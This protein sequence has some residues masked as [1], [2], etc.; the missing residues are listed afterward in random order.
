MRRAAIL[1]GLLVVVGLPFTRPWA[2]DDTA[3]YVASFLIE[4]L[5]SATALVGISL[6]LS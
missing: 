2:T 3:W 6:E 5:A 4:G 1:L